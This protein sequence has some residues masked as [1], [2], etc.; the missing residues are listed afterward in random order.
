MIRT[1]K[2]VSC[3]RRNWIL[4]QL[5]AQSLYSDEAREQ[6]I[7]AC[8]AIVCSQL[9]IHLLAPPPRNPPFDSIDHAFAG[10][11]EVKSGRWMREEA[12]SKAILTGE[13]CRL[14]IIMPI[15]RFRRPNRQA[16]SFVGPIVKAQAQ[17]FGIPTWYVLPAFPTPGMSDHRAVPA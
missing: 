16:S 10:C 12:N 6:R 5:V 4:L 14:V 7:F 17:A 13:S 1:K 9:P 3:M 11:W 2:S 15:L 8:P